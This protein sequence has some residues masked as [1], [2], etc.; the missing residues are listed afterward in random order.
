MENT[1]YWI[2]EYFKVAIAYGFIMFLW[3]SVVFYKI[4]KGKSKT[5]WFGFCTTVSVMTATVVVLGLGLIHLLKPWVL[6]L[7][8]YGSFVAALAIRNREKLA[9]IS[10]FKRIANGTYGT[11]SYF[12][13]LLRKIVKTFAKLFK[14]AWSV[15]SERKTEYIFLL[16]IIAWG[17]LYFSWGGF[18]DFSYGF[19]DQYVH[20]KWIYG[21]MN[22]QIFID[23]I[24]PEGMHCFLLLF[25]TLFG[26]DTYT[27]L[28]FVAGI[29]TFTFFMAVYIFLKEVFNSRFTV[30][31]VLILFLSVDVLCI[32][33][34][35]SMSRLQWTLPQEFSFYSVL[36]CG[37]FLIRYLK[38]DK[39]SDWKHLWNENLIIFLLAI[40]TSLSIHYYG[41]I[42]A[43]FVCVVI[44]IPYF[45][46]VFKFKNFIQLLAA[47]ILSVVLAAAPIGG[48]LLTGHRFQGSILWALSVIEDSDPNASLSLSD[49]IELDTAD[50]QILEKEDNRPK[51]TE[52]PTPSTYEE[53]SSG[54][55]QEAVKLSFKE[56]VKGFY[57]SALL[58]IKKLDSMTYN[59]LYRRDRADLILK[60]TAFG[61]CL[62]VICTIAFKILEKTKKIKLPETKGYFIVILI[63]VF[64]MV[65][66]NPSALGL[67]SIIAGC[68]LCAFNRIWNFAM[69]CIAFDIIGTFLISL[70]EET[71][72]SLLS[73][74]GVMA[75]FVGTIKTGNYR[76]YLYYELTRYNSAVMTTRSIVDSFPKNSFTVVSTVDELY[77]VIEKGFH[78]EITDFLTKSTEDSYSIPTPY[79]FIYVE[80]HPIV[81][82]QNHFFTGPSWLGKE[83]KYYDYYY[84]RKGQGD[85]IFQNELIEVDSIH[86]YSQ[87]SKLYTYPEVRAQ[88]ES[89]LDM[90]CDMFDKRYPNELNVYYEDDDYVCYYF[91]Q[92]PRALYDLSVKDLL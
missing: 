69:I 75:I 26:I 86:K 67:P 78:E 35:Y 87:N 45:T 79:V 42:I 25:P 20:H 82:A 24:Y 88:I 47:V 5:F 39:R 91:E 46:K 23:G 90:W 62:S 57:D 15:L 54:D 27:A 16:I 40:A 10:D 80:K 64:F 13:D 81:Y 53:N 70:T 8:Y 6:F 65:M 33:E 73:M 85:D 2:I 77:S 38:D 21:L 44:V 31:L 58:T 41:T 92:N 83:G 72:V 3:P 32:D 68:R 36:I 51:K 43:F 60:F 14:Y 52:E 59:T 55:V 19:G 11:K 1:V 71:I 28:L 17:V 74:I 9:D 34:I 66:Y 61:F 50:G 89:E 30:Y 48:A 76:G 7:L 4:L 84:G 29:H 63:S 56:R 18:Y 12:D 22:G 49:Y 37:A